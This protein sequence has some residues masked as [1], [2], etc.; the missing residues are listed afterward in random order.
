[1]LFTATFYFS[2]AFIIKEVAD[3]AKERKTNKTEFS[4]KRGCFMVA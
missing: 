3:I 4:S 2:Q 1:M